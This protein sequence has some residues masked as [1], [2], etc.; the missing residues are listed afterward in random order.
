MKP[1][2]LSLARMCGVSRGTVDRVLNGR[3]YVSPEVRKKVLRAVQETGYVHPRT[4]ASSDH[5]AQIGF[6]VAK[7]ENDYFRRQTERG[8]R[9]AGRTLR[10]GELS[11]QVETMGSRSDR[12]YIQRIDHLLENGAAGIILN[13]ADNVL[14]RTKI[15]DLAAQGVPVVTYNSD[16]PTSRRVCHVGQD[17]AKSG[18]VAAGLLARSL[19]PRDKILAVTGNLEFL[20]SRSRVESFCAHAASLGIGGDRVQLA[21]CFER[22]DLTYDAVLEALQRDSSVR[23]VYMGTESV[24]ACMDAIKKAHLRYKVHV[25]ANDLTQPAIR[26]LKTGMLDFVVEQDF[27]TQA[28][29]AILVMYALLAHD[30]PPKTAVR[31]V[32]TS[33]Y[34]KELL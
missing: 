5:A 15:D 14:L 18:Q 32:E 10:P 17:L 31:Y 27:S 29:E 6:L 11:L 34:T 1:T 4:A 2:I 8:I 28:Y 21:Q 23:G 3:P 7:W 13:A 26:G 25:V 24:P 16:L 30:R 9:R 33:I 19:G 22:Y 12:E 20:S